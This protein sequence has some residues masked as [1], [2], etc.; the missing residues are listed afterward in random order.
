MA[1]TKARLAIA[2]QK[3]LG[4]SR[5]KSSLLIDAFVETIKKAL[6]SGEDILITRFGKFSVEDVGSGR[7]RNPG[8]SGALNRMITFKCS[9]VLRKKLNGKKKG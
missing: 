4:L 5:K 7:N 3:R 1:V 2:V 9:P 6:T 8:K